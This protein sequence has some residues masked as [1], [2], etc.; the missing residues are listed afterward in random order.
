VPAAGDQ[1]A[2]RPGR[3]ESGIDVDG[4]RVEPPGKLEDLRLADGQVPVLVDRAREVVL[5]ITVFTGE[6]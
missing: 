5:E 3:G 4:L 1:A 2:E 6:P